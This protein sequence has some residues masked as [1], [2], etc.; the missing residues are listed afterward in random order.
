MTGGKTVPRQKN[1]IREWLCRAGRIAEGHTGKPPAGM[2]LTAQRK[3]GATRGTTGNHG[4]TVPAW[5]HAPWQ[6]AQTDCTG[7]RHH[8]IQAIRTTGTA[9]PRQFPSSSERIAAGPGPAKHAA[10]RHN[11]PRQ[12]E[13]LPRQPAGRL[14]PAPERV[15][16]AP[17]AGTGARPVRR[18]AVRAIRQTLGHVPFETP[19]ASTIRP[20]VSRNHRSVFAHF[21]PGGT[22]LTPR[23]LLFSMATVSNGQTICTS[24]PARGLSTFFSRTFTAQTRKAGSVLQRFRPV[25]TKMVP[26]GRLEL[27]RRNLH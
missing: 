14:G 11:V 9:R 7:S 27:P 26:K 13:R 19:C 8:T 10:Q 17:G 1:R 24:C 22:V 6:P 5:A 20:V 21:W 18:H 15:D 16:S 25:Q 4:H 12:H 23:V 3:S 2:A